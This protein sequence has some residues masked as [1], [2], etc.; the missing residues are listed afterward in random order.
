MNIEKYSIGIG[1]RFGREGTAQLQALQEAH[2][3]G[4]EVVPVWNKSRREH[5]IIG[6]SPEDTRKEADA[7]VKGSAWKSSYYVD[8]DH[9]A[10]GTVDA[11][12]ASSDFFTIDV[13]DWIGKT[14][15]SKEAIPFIKRI[16]TFQRTIPLPGVSGTI[17][18]TPGLVQNF[19]AKYYRA[20]QEA[21]KV[22]RHIAERRD[23]G[24]FI[25]EVSFDEASVAQSPE[26][27][28]L[29]LAAVAHEGIPVQ[30]I[31]PKFVGTF[32]KGVDYVG[33]VASFAEQ[34]D[35][36]VAVVK[37]AADLFGLPPSLKLSVHTGS[38][39]FSLY[40]FMHRSLEKHGAGIH[41]KT[42]GTTWL[43]E[44]IGLA[45][46]GGDG[47][48]FAK[49]VYAASLKEFDVL[50]QPYLTVID[51]R[52]SRLPSATVVEQW[53]AQEFVGALRHD[54]SSPGY[55]PDLRQLLHVGYKIAANRWS[56]FDALLTEYRASV[57]RNV[58]ENLY[59]RHILP[60]F[61]GNGR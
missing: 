37:G 55:N 9:I 15:V 48:A 56:T 16:E 4:I 42:A 2:R 8:A 10:L 24:T 13:A 50:V 6:T 3:N 1:D 28:F 5:T 61:R 53:S 26:E 60:V 59:Q 46:A 17:S 27:L 54:K 32:L 35:V 43:E 11:F 38:D 45:E 57:E 19:I 29:I 58:T 49:T 44:L 52:R 51:I 39:K 21:T 41:L 22:Y 25:I 14:V 33:D 31:A 7:A 20:I 18:V 47:L 12:L 34:F 23:P 40:P 36:D 30:T